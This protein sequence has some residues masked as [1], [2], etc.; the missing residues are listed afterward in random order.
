MHARCR[1]GVKGTAHPKMKISPLPP[2]ASGKSG[3]VPRSSQQKS[4]AASSST[5]E[6][7]GDLSA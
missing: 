4:V 6:E 2:C 7:A 1:A 3:Q 5:T